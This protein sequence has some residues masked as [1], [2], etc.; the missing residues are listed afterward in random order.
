MA[1]GIG[2]LSFSLSFLFRLFWEKGESE[3]VPSRRAAPSCPVERVNG[4]KRR[5]ESCFRRSACE[6][7]RQGFRNEKKGLVGPS[8]LHRNRAPRYRA[9][10]SSRSG[11]W[12]SSA[13]MTSRASWSSC[14]QA[15]PAISIAS[16]S[17]PPADVHGKPVMSEYRA[18]AQACRR[19][20]N[21]A[22]H[23]AFEMP[24]AWAYA[25]AFFSQ[26]RSDIPSGIK[27]P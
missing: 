1:F 7:T 21:D 19:P 14:R 24:A 13:L 9:T 5:G 22:P 8:L 16:A 27:L 6:L 17:V 11:P 12:P 23:A 4:R 18:C 2:I 20:C 26:A 3:G 15:A 10:T 25:Y